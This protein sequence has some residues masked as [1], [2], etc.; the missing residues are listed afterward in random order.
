[1]NNN[2]TSKNIV[3]KKVTHESVTHESECQFE[4][5]EENFILRVMYSIQRM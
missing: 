5:E 3:R 4:S 1:M 2:T